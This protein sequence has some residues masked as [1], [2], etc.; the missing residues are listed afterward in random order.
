[1]NDPFALVTLK[2]ER[3]LK[4]DDKLLPDTYTVDQAVDAL[5]FGRFQVKL[6]ILTG[7]AWVRSTFFLPLHGRLS[8]EGHWRWRTRWR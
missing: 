5:G 2:C 4:Y 7:L 6:S 3:S 8:L 1:M